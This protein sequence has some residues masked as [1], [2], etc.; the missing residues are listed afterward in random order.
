MLIETEFRSEDVPAADRFA[1]WRKRMGRTHAPMDMS[2]H[3]ADFWAHQRL[4]ELGG[5]GGRRPSN[6]WSFDGR[7]S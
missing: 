6:R 2:D 1:C 3:A 5:V 4:L 7:R